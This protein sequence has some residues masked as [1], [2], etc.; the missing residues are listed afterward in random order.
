MQ[1][2]GA[3]YSTGVRTVGTTVYLEGMYNTGKISTITALY[4]GIT[5]TAIMNANGTYS[6]TIPNVT[7]NMLQSSIITFTG[8]NGICIT[9]SPVT[10]TCSIGGG[11]NYP[12]RGMMMN[13]QS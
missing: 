12:V 6:I 13:Y 7:A 2:T 9:T 3:D 4:S 10:F 1:I 8:S 5:Y 11:C